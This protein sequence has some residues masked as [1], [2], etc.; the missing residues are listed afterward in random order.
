M[1][2]NFLG[3]LFL[4]MPHFIRLYLAKF[5]SI[6]LYTVDKR[7]KKD[8]IANL[9]FAYN[10]TLDEN[11]KREIIKTNYINLVYNTILF[12]ML[13]VSSKQR[14]L[15]MIDIDNPQI[16]QNLLDN[17]EYIVFVTAHYGNWEYTTPAFSC[18]FNHKIT[19]IARMTKYEIINKYLK[20]VRSKFNIAIIDKK[21][22]AIP[23]IK[24]LKKDKVVGIVTDQNTADNEGELVEFFS[25]KV[26]HTPIAS[27]LAIKYNA[28]IVHFFS[29]Y[30]SDYKKLKIKILPPIEFQRTNNTEEDIH[31]LTQIQS[32]MLEEIIKENPK[33]WLWFHRKFKNQY[34]E[35]YR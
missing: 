15:D 14:I 12:F 19:A 33:E 25:K 20:L 18:Y 35:I 16:I 5:I 24:A 31:K 3:Y 9:N 7:R 27:L 13:S 22:A 30:S 1:L 21:G 29:Y 2:F 32:T 34:E 17:N 8:I 23:L 4:Y 26:R 28:K 11:I 10:G 6:I